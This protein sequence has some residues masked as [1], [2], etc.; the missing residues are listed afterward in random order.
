VSRLVWLLAL[1][2]CDRLLGLDSIPPLHDAP[3]DVRALDALPDGLVLSGHDED[4]DG[5]DDTIDLCPSDFDQTMPQP[6]ADGDGVGDA[7]DPHPDLPIDYIAY[8]DPLISFG[9]WHQLAGTWTSGSD[10]VSVGFQ[11]NSS[12]ALLEHGVTD[13]ELFK[14]PT[15]E[16]W[17]SSAITQ[18]ATED[19]GAF[20]ATDTVDPPPPLASGVFCYDDLAVGSLAY[21]ERRAVANQSKEIDTPFAATLPV[22][23]RVVA[24][25]ETNDVLGGPVACEG[26]SPGNSHMATETNPGYAQPITS[27]KV[28]LYTFDAAATFTSVT[29]FATH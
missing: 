12:M 7:C 10:D 16:V 8:F 24:N 27:G 14:N 9:P 22:R 28:G 15:I 1:A 11:G 4:N 19:V 29:V 3:I 6:D 13:G 20:V 21:Y 26:Y 23:I 17:V 18:L 2:S 5:I 25:S